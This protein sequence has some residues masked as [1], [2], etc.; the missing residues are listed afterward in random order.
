MEDFK[1]IISILDERSKKLD[2]AFYNSLL[3]Y[4]E[5][6]SN[7]GINLVNNLNKKEMISK[8]LEFM[9]DEEIDESSFEEDS[10]DENDEQ[11]GKYYINPLIYNI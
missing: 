7:F 2:K 8:N 11:Q 6:D 1:D 4:N 3:Q 9:D 5:D 10:E